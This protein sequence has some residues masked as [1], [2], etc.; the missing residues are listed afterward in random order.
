MKPELLVMH[1]QLQRTMDDLGDGFIMHPI[2]K[3]EDP[4]KLIKDVAANIR[5]IATSGSKG[6]SAAFMDH[7]PNLEMIG[8]FGVGYDSIDISHAKSRGIVVTNTPG[9]LVEGVAEMG[10]TLLLSTTRRV[11]EGDR[12]VR[13]GRWAKDGDM[14]LG[15]SLAGKRLGIVGLGDIGSRLAELASAFKMKISYYGPNEK[16]AYP[17]PY[18]PNLVKLAQDSDYLMICCKGGEETRK[19][20]GAD[21]IEALGPEG[22]LINISRGTVV[23]EAALLAALQSGKLGF[24]GLD[25]FEKEPQVPAGFM[26]LDN[27]VLVPHIGSATT[28]TRI[29]MGDLVTENI[30]A[31]F[32]GK[33][34]PTPVT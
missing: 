21:V 9:V 26:E 13:A 30:R 8:S 23:D 28:E 5:G 33:P 24:A 11:A 22:M 6:A 27:V 15:R 31:Y 10:M 16:P 2:W 17:Y 4:D 3:A 29:A 32:S 19:L 1:P 18:Q 12:Y 25:V 34:V 20:V 14:P 7:F